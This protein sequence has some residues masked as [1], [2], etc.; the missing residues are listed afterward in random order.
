MQDKV[1]NQ[2]ISTHIA[3]APIPPSH[4]SLTFPIAPWPRDIF[5]VSRNIPKA[6]FVYPGSEVDLR[7]IQ[8]LVRRKVGEK[9]EMGRLVGRLVGKLSELCDGGI[10][11][12]AM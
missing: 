10:G 11:A 8:E 9:A 4:S 1:E 5:R 3:S 2:N 12:L 6:E 7:S